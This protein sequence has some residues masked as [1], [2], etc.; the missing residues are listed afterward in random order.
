MAMGRRGGAGAPVTGQEADNS[1]SNI[2]T[3]QQGFVGGVAGE[4]AQQVIDNPA[5]PLVNV[6]AEKV[7]GPTTSNKIEAPQRNPTVPS[8]LFTRGSSDASIKGKPGYYN[9]PTDAWANVRNQYI[10]IFHIPTKKSV[11][12]KSFVTEFKDSF[13][14]DYTKEKVFGRMDPIATYKRTGRTISLGWDMPCTGLPEAKENMAMINLLIQML[15]PIYDTQTANTCGATTMRSGPIF[16]IKMGNLIIQPGST[17]TAGPAETLGLSGIIEG[18]SYD[19]DL[20]QGVFD[21]GWSRGETVGGPASYSG[22]LYPKL[23]KASIKFTVLHDTPLGWEENGSTPKLRHGGGEGNY[24]SRFPYGGDNSP[25]I[26]RRGE[27]KAPFVQKQDYR[28]ILNV[29]KEL[30]MRRASVRSQRL[31]QTADENRQLFGLPETIF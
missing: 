6:P 27:R 7:T 19:P 24:E 31:M 16:K 20:K 28:A 2:D 29:E 12:F 21:P 5:P 9:D 23:T 15:Y 26:Q 17:Q 1:P 3:N 10:E 4:A 11:Y 25:L 13:D 18:F 14:T 8:P 30:Q 22:E